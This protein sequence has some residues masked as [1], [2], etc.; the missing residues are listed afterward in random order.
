MSDK[1]SEIAKLLESLQSQNLDLEEVIALRKILQQN[2]K[3]IEKKELELQPYE[4]LLDSNKSRLTILPIEYKDVWKMYKLQFASFWKAE[5]IDFSKD[6]DDFETLNSDEQFFLKK[7]LAF[8]A[9]SDGI[10]N[11]NIRERFSKDIQIM[12][13]QVTYALQSAMENVHGEVYSLMLDNIVQD[14]AERLQ[15]FNAVENDPSIKAMADWAFKWIESSDSFAHR[16]IAFAIVEGIFFSGAFAS[17]FWFKIYKGKNKKFLNGL[18]TSNEF[19][20]RDEGLH[21]DFAC[22][23][24]S[25]LNNK[26]ASSEVYKII[27]EAV[28]ISQNFMRIALPCRH[29]GMNTDMMD[30][31]IEYIADRLMVDLGYNKIYNKTNPFQFMETMGMISRTNFFEKRPSQYQSSTVLNTNKTREITISED[32]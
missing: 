18:V 16:L 25:H 15:L 6:R 8:F 7:I 30:N 4:P 26:L 24:Y 9:A 3:T 1:I 14:S 17:I 5:E 10:V 31:Y 11:F 28:K 23:L 19:I 32:F 29:I 12:E 21:C 13:A 2:I 20:A 22:L 27:D